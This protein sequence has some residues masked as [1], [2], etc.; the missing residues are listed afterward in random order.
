VVGNFCVPQQHIQRALG[1]FIIGSFLVC[2]IAD[3]NFISY[4]L[5]SLEPSRCPNRGELLRIRVDIA[6][7]RDN[8]LFRSDTNV[9]GIDAGGSAVI[10][11]LLWLEA[12]G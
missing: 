6:G 4:R 2:G 9:S 7:E 1:N 12:I 8:S 11:R 5:H 3:L 10:E